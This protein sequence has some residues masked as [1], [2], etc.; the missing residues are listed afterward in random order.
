MA[1]RLGRARVPAAFRSR[2]TGDSGRNGRTMMSGSAG[3][4]PEIN[5]YRHG[6]W[7]TVD[8][9]Q[10]LGVRDRQEIGA[11]DQDAADRRERLRVAQ[12]GLAPFRVGKQLGQPGNGGDELDTDADEGGAAEEQQ[13][14]DRGGVARGTGGAGVE[15]DAPDEDAPAAEEVGQIAADQPEYAAGHRRDPEEHADPVVERGRPGDGAGQLHEGR[16]R[17]ERQHQN[18][19]DVEREADGGNRADHPLSGRQRYHGV[20]EPR[21]PGATSL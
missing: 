11:R 18:L 4:R 1:T 16:P 15:Q 13:P 12:D 7:R 10:R 21:V 3:M 19:V 6:A 9:R 20:S 17:D 14:P 2:H 5:V 8:G